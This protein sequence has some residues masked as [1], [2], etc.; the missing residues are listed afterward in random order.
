MR[1]EVGE[2]CNIRCSYICVSLW[3]TKDLTHH[4]WVLLFPW[5][6][7]ECF[8]CLDPFFIICTVLGCLVRSQHNAISHCTHPLTVSLR[9]KY[10]S[11]FSEASLWEHRMFLLFCNRATTNS[12][13]F[14]LNCSEKGSS[15]M[16]WLKAFPCKLCK[17]CS[18]YLRMLRMVI[19][20]SRVLCII[21]KKAAINYRC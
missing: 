3:S 19:T 12:I 8:Q 2:G 9:R 21:T 16:L 14:C 7:C 11:L 5:W 13:F 18:C 6:K 15:R 1:F 10:E 20:P 4:P 17:P